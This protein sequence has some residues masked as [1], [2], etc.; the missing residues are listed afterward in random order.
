MKAKFI[1]LAAA[2]AFCVA[3]IVCAQDPLSSWNETAPKKAI[4]DF[5]ERVTKQGSPDFVQLNERIATFD[6]DGTLWVEQPIYTQFVFAIAR[7]KELAPK[8]PEWNQQQPF[9]AVLD[10]DMKALAASGERGIVQLMMATHTGMTTDE[11][12]ASVR[13]WITTAQ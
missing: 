9:K 4:I 7:V 13:R 10:G 5:V 11:F 6:N 12:E 2:V 3:S 8:H 1:T